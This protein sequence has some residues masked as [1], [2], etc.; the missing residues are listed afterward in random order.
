[1]GSSPI[2][3]GLGYAIDGN[4]KHAIG[5]SIF[6]V[7]FPLKLVRV[8]VGNADSESQK[9]L[10]TFFKKIFGPHAGDI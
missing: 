5:K 6:A 7:N 4:I 9:S 2:R 8:S 1:M 10:H 3:E